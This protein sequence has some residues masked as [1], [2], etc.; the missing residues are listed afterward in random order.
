MSVIV[1]NNYFQIA[2]QLP[3]IGP[4]DTTISVNFRWLVSRISPE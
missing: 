4:N 2:R 3:G 1:Y